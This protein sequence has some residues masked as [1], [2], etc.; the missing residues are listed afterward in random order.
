MRA[1]VRPVVQNVVS[2]MNVFIACCMKATDWPTKR[3]F[4]YWAYIGECQSVYAGCMALWFSYENNQPNHHGLDARVF[5]PSS[6]W[7]FLSFYGF[8][9]STLVATRHEWEHRFLQ[10]IEE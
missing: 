2:V 8:S 3:L 5:W 9:S 7:Y 6:K 10:N 4:I 1:I